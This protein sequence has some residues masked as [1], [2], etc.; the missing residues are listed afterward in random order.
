M[1][2]SLRNPHI[3]S[4]ESGYTIRSI[5]RFRQSSP[6][7][8]LSRQRA[9]RSIGSTTQA[10]FELGDERSFEPTSDRLKPIPVQQHATICDPPA[11]A[12]VLKPIKEA[13][14]REEVDE[15]IDRGPTVYGEHVCF[16]V[17]DS[18]A[19]GKIDAKPPFLLAYPR[20]HAALASH[21]GGR[22]AHDAIAMA[23]SS[24]RTS[25]SELLS[26]LV[27]TRRISRRSARSKRRPR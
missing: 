12:A 16:A 8:R 24:C 21:K 15:A 3:A 26:S 7:R 6:D 4:P 2:S 27:E 20:A 11:V 1:A 25:P 14:V 17:R 13:P 18:S 23:G 19:G 10:L 22:A 9:I 5:G